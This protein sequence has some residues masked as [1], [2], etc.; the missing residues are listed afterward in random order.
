MNNHNMDINNITLITNLIQ[1]SQE[2]NSENF[3]KLND[4]IDKFAEEI[5]KEIRA[6]FDPQL[7]AL[8]EE[9][10]EL[11]TVV[12]KQQ[13]FIERLDNDQRANRII[14]TGVP[15]DEVLVDGDTTA[16]SDADKCELLFNLIDSRPTV[17]DICRLGKP[18]PNKSRPIK[19]T[20]RNNSDRADVID[21]ASVLA[22]RTQPFKSVRIKK[23]THPAVRH[24]WARLHECLRKE[25]EKHANSGYEIKLDFQNRQLL[26]DGVVIDSFVNPFI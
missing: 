16:F 23:D 17:Q 4:R 18:N 3:Q 22:T 10:K 26:R 5:K 11:R 21:K 6:E 24:E 1:T 2:Q 8:K 13:A 14:I 20:L 7:T 9:I 12:T 15:E 19:V 25:K